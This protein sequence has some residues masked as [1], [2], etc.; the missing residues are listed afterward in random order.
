MFVVAIGF[1]MHGAWN[2]MCLARKEFSMPLVQRP[3]ST[4]HALSILLNGS[5][6]QRKFTAPHLFGPLVDT[7]ACRTVH[8]MNFF[9]VI[10]HSAV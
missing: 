1:T 4:L 9:L 6:M 10:M 3:T 5:N 2:T 8:I 7:F